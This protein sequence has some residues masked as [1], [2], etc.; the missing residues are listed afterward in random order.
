M[1]PARRFE[2]IC[3]RGAPTEFHE[4]TLASFERALE[5]GADALE[6]DVHVTAD[7]VIVVH[8]DPVLPPSA[9]PA[10]LRRAEIARTQWADLETVE[11]ADEARIPRLS[12][13]L[14][15]V[16]NRAAIY[17]EIKGQDIESQ[18]ADAI[19]RA[20]CR[21]AVH[22]FDHGAVERMRLLSPALPRGI[23][24]DRYPRDVANAMAKTEARDVWP[25]WSLIDQRLVDAVH[26]EGGRV[27]AWTVNDARETARLV[28]LGVDGI[29]SDDLRLIR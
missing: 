24:F 22:S 11:I 9:Q 7:G 3:H 26:Q 29:C 12:D 13:V 19:G 17:V 1:E 6:L 20:T 10:S 25:K 28:D 16:G 8:H 2:R 18:V 27:I 15:M 14:T 21:C 23:L 4:N 5:R